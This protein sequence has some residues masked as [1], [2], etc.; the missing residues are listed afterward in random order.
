M[1]GPGA[2]MALHIKP[3]ST[4]HPLQ[5]HHD[6]ALTWNRMVGIA[7]ALTAIHESVVSCFRVIGR[8]GLVSEPHQYHM[9][10]LRV[11]D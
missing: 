7:V 3:I 6:V 10:R 8:S 4:C 5:G 11:S 9:A 2:E 1:L